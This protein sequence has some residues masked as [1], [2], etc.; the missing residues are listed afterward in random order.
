M[1]MKNGIFIL[2]V[3]IW[4]G[5]VFYF[6]HQQ[7]TGSGNTSKMVATKI[8]E[9]MDINNNLSQEQKDE[10]ISKAEP[11]IRKL[12]HYS[13]YL[14]GGILIMNAIYH[15]IEQQNRAIVV[16]TLTGIV[17]AASDEIHQLFIIGR[18]G[19]I[20]DV[21]IDSLGILTGIVIFLLFQKIMLMITHKTKI[22]G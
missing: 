7:G 18:S 17:Y 21:L 9:I 3:V 2:L 13:I 15:T 14:L 8:V 1:K 10:N 16:S 5:T 22:R 4:M 12:A 6:S 11:F 20:V 19:R